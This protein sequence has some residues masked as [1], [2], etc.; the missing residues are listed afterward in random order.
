MGT[1]IKNDL[2]ILEALEKSIEL[3]MSCQPYIEKVEAKIISSKL[4]SGEHSYD[5]SE[6]KGENLVIKV[7]S[8]YGKVRV[9]SGIK[10]I[11]ELDFPLMYIESIEE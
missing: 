9:H 4:K 10:Y 8:K 11:P 6:L 3:T 7:V 2:K 1:P 5:Y